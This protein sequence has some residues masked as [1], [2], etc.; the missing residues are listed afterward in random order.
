MRFAERLKKF[1]EMG[2]TFKRPQEHPKLSLCLPRVMMLDGHQ[3][4]GLVGVELAPI[5]AGGV[6][7]LR[8]L[9]ALVELF[10]D[11]ETTKE[12]DPGKL[13]GQ[14]LREAA[15]HLRQHLN[16]TAAASDCAH[17]EHEAMHQKDGGSVH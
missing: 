1:P 7:A 4:Q 15:G 8:L 2:V 13:F 16:A 6:G 12:A 3:A 10:E 5:V 17:A 14:E 11:L 9:S